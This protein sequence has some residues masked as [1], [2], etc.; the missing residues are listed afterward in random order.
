[1]FAEP[2]AADASTDSTLDSI[3]GYSESRINQLLA[4]LTIDDGATSTDAVPE[5]DA[6]PPTTEEIDAAIAEQHHPEPD[7]GDKPVETGHS[8]LA[9]TQRFEPLQATL[10]YDL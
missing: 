5:T 7:L 2:P 4:S 3:F 10:E 1:M 8:P 6:A 9:E